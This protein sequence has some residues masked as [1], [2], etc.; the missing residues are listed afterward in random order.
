MNKTGMSGI[1]QLRV[2]VSAMNQLSEDFLYRF[3]V[4]EILQLHRVWVASKFDIFPDYWTKN[5]IKAALNG[6]PPDWRSEV[7]DPSFP[8]PVEEPSEAQLRHAVRQVDLLAAI[9]RGAGHSSQGTPSV[10]TLIEDGLLWECP[11][12]SIAHLNACGH[13]CLDLLRATIETIETDTS[14][15]TFSEGLRRALAPR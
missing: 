13:R 6:V 2:V 12:T 11:E 7:G 10:A 4:N 15:D 8:K 14:A 9:E 1:D 5:Q 3:D